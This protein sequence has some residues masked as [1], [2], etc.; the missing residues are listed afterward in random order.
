MHKAEALY[1]HTLMGHE[2]TVY[3]QF[4]VTHAVSLCSNISACTIPIQIF[5]E[6]REMT[7]VGVAS[8]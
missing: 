3:M 4:N 6:E 7:I 2:Y 1:R 5:L 8:T